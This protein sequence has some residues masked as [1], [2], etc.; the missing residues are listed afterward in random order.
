MVYTVKR[1]IFVTMNLI[2]Q[3]KD[4]II[5]LCKRFKVS[6]LWVFGSVLTPRFNDE[7]DI[8]LL[9]EFDREKLD[10][11]DF[12]DNF[13]GLIHSVESV[14]GRKVD[15]VVNSSIRNPYFRAEVDNTRKILWST[16]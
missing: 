10:L 6:K 13:F 9:V 15:M 11:L 5:A 3:H 4:K 1:T 2:E 12:A 16:T 7:S 14:V 8:D